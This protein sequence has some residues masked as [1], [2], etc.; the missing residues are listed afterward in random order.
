VDVIGD[1][2]RVAHE[3]WRERLEREGWRYGERFDPAR[4]TH[5]ALVCFDRLSA[6]DRDQARLAVEAEHLPAQLA[7]LI[8]YPRGPARPFTLEEMTRGRSVQLEGDEGATGRIESWESDE[9]GLQLIRV[10]WPDGALVEYAPQ[11]QALLRPEER[12]HG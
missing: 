3:Y 8:D 6:A 7:R 10:R 12:P 4:R 5:D 9:N 11:E 1:L 2:A